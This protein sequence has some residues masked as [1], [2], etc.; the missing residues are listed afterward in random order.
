M[1]EKGSKEQRFKEKGSKERGWVM[2]S[3]TSALEEVKEAQYC[4]LNLAGKNENYHTLQTET[5]E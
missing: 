4:Q 3:D 1:I 5:S 2:V